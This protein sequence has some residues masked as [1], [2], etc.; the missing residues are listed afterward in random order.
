MCGSRVSPTQSLCFP[1]KDVRLYGFEVASDSIPVQVKLAQVQA[2]AEYG[3][4][5]DVRAT[6]DGRETSL[7]RVDG[8]VT[9]QY[10]QNGSNGTAVTITK[11]IDALGALL[12][13]GGN[14]GFSF[15]VDRG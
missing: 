6:D 14:N 15:N 9:V 13:S 10:F 3:A 11:A 1:R 2:A 5:V 8:A 12:C 7:E 4:G